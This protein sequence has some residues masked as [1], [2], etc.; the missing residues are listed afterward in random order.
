MGELKYSILRYAPSLISG[1][2]INLAA[3]FNYFSDFDHREFYCIKNWSR[4]SAFDDSVSIPMLKDIMLDMEEEIGTPLD[5][6]DFSLE[7]FCSKYHNE[8]YFDTAIKFSDISDAQLSE[9]IERIKHMY[10]S[11]DYKKEERP[12]SEDQKK[13]LAM[14]LKSKNVEYSRNSSQM[15][16]YN[17]KITYDFIFNEYGVKFF[18]LNRKKKY[19]STLNSA[20]AW[21]WNCKNS[22]NNLKTIILYDTVNENDVE[23]R[24]ILNIFRASTDFVINVH[25]GF[26]NL[27][28][29]ING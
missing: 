3:V 2:T 8:L 14:V 25:D 16:L 6:P 19:G 5:N 15:G 20:K 22:P 23:V 18:N 7:Q 1:E 28:S 9:E 17:E 11:F 13:F 4:V 10:F 26:G 27:V 12:D 29:M 21:A 24:A